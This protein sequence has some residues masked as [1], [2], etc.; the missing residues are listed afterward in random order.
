V[1]QLVYGPRVNK[2]NE[3]IKPRLGGV[4]RDPVREGSGTSSHA[5]G[6]VT[7]STLQLA[8]TDATV[9]L[10]S[11]T[12]RSNDLDRAHRESKIGRSID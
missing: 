10:L 1:G 11:P 7:R 2:S 9:A 3:H 5:I 8:H 4:V 6:R 12:E